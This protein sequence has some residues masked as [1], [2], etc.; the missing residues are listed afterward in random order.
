M[1]YFFFK[2]T[3]FFDGINE[4]E[5]KEL[6]NC[7]N[8]REEHFKKDEI[9]FS[10]GSTTTEIG[11]V[12]S[13]S[14]NIVVNFYWGTSSIFGHVEKG[15][16]FA[17]NYAAVPH[18]ELLC[19]VVAAEDCDILFLNMLRVSTTCSNNCAFHNRLIKNLLR[20]CAKKNLGLSTRMMHI[21]PKAIRNRLLSYLSEQAL[22]NESRHFCIPFNRQQLADYLGVDRS[23]L[24]S[25]L[26]K[27]Q[28]DG[29]I[30]YH[31]N[32]FTLNDIENYS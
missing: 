31:K 16:I 21:A 6:L 12:E 5:I 1:D 24:S 10:A 17:E 23:A 28:K 11:M 14:V 9:I 4:G 8:A 7:L 3:P 15:Q 30:T 29:L 32:E 20:I 2:N 26:S 22:R 13:G 25:E 27:M 18:Q 19:D